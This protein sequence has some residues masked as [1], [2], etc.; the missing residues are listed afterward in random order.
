MGIIEVSSRA[1]NYG[2]KIGVEPHGD[3]HQFIAD[4]FA[5][6]SLQFVNDWLEEK[7]LS[8]FI[9]PVFEKTAREERFKKQRNTDEKQ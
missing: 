2:A 8:K 9:K 5:E 1:R 6:K 7:N 4:F 3:M